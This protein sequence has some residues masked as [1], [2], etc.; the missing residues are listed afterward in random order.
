MNFHPLFQFAKRPREPHRASRA[1][2]PQ[3]SRRGLSVEVE[4]DAQ[5]EYLSLC[6]AQRV[7]GSLELSR[8]DAVEHRLLLIVR[9]A[10]ADEAF[11]ALRR[12]A[13]ERK[14]SKA[15]ERAIRQSQVRSDARR[16]S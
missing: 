5:R 1:S 4:D 12:R 6:S 10:L 8:E 16:G 13:S 11:L 15:I 2:D 14:W 7:Q 3:H 9:A